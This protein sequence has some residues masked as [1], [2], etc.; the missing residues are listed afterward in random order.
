METYLNPGNSGFPGI[1][2]DTYVDKTGLISCINQAIDTPQK[3]ICV[4]RS[5]RFGKS[6]AAK[7]KDKLSPDSSRDYGGDVLPVGINYDR[8]KKTHECRIE[9]IFAVLYIMKK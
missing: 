6:F 8:E 3:L 9:K 7:M 1:V 2:R 4:S 5:R